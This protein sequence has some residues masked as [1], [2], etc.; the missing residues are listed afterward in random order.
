MNDKGSEWAPVTSGIPQGSILGPI[1]FL[2]FINDL[3]NTAVSTTKLFADDTKL[4]RP[5][6]SVQ[7][8]EILQDDLDRLW[9]WSEKWQLPFNADKCKIIHYGPN[10][11]SHN[12]SIG[13]VNQKVPLACDSEEKDL[14]V[15]FDQSLKFSVHIAEAASKAR[16][17]MGLIIHSFVAL[18]EQMFLT[19]YK[20]KVRPILEYG[21]TVFSPMYK[22][23]VIILEKV[24]RKATK[25]VKSLKDKPYPERLKQLKLPTLVYRRER[26][27]M[28]QVFKLLKH[29]EDM[30][31][32][33]FFE[34]VEGTSATT[35]GHPLKL[36]K[37]QYSSNLRANAFANRVINEWN[38][39]PKEVAECTTVNQFKTL[40]ENAWMDR[41]T[42]YIPY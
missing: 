1:L 36:K 8:K 23:D 26:A 7:D 16:R 28:I 27:N 6:S 42:K 35:R 14:G 18:D 10:N 2:I 25:A 5:V 20:S 15:K 24:Q 17:I 40:L 4:Y 22:K 12:Y 13:P 33:V 38:A 29:L 9:E 21:S 32:T 31:P 41:P 3:P 37:K 11:P 30:D 19:L 39:L 34:L